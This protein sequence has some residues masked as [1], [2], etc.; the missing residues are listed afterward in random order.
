MD[1]VHPKPPTLN[2]VEQKKQPF[3]E[4]GQPI[5]IAGDVAQAASLCSWY[6]AICLCTQTGSSC[7]ALPFTEGLREEAC[8]MSHVLRKNRETDIK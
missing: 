1:P 8:A 7:Y 2:G 5:T 3:S 4:R 6:I